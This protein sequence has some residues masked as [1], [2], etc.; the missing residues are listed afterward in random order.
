M[1]KNLGEA[2]GF[3]EGDKVRM[4]VVTG[5]DDGN[6]EYREYPV[7]TEAYIDRIDLF[8]GV[9]KIAFTLIIGPLGTDESI[10]NIFDENDGPVTEFF[11]PLNPAGSS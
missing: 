4:L 8:D 9:Q 5:V 1:G 6:S 2:F 11:V 10:A 3:K 7:G